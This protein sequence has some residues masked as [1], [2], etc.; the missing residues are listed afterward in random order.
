[1]PERNNSIKLPRIS[2][3]DLLV[4]LED[5]GLKLIDVRSPDA[6]N[7]WKLKDEKRGG[8]IRG[9]RSLPAR[10][11]D[12]IDWIEMVRHKD[13]KPE[14]NLAVYGYRKDETEKVA[15][16]LIRTGYPSVS[17]YLDFT[18]EWSGNP[19]L[20]MERLPRYKHLV[21]PRWLRS[22][23]DT[24]TAPEYQNDRLV[25]AHAHYRNREDYL[26]G[27]IPGAVDLDTNSLESP[28]TWN[29]RSPKEIEETLME[30]GIDTR[31]T[32]VL[33]GRFSFP[34]NRDPF[35]GSSAGQLAAMRCALIMLYAGV[36]DV[37]I[38]N[39]G[40]RAWLEAGY[41]TTT[42][43]TGR[44]PV[45]GFGA[46]I[47]AHP[48]FVVDLPEAKEVLKAPDRN[49]VSVRSWAEY[50]GEV[51]GY[52][53]IEKRG[54]IPGSVFGNCGSDA[55][56]MENYRNLDHTM[57]EYHEIEKMWRE[58]GITPDRYNSFYCGTGWRASEAFISAWLMGWSRISVFDGG[59]FQWSN[60]EGNPCEKGAPP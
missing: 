17:V 27:H 56:H 35:P 50:T 53:Y 16:Q 45:S 24:G 1:M 10:W 38:L 46:E 8:H 32:V 57:R 47:P 48:E 23:M 55:Y 52:D 43:E 41:E 44:H 31:T 26:E 9:A 25:I 42:A 39:G 29:R 36:E 11:A 34:D 2:T 58:G 12:Y 40:L 49:L 13:I 60:H 20:P 19:D 54:R 33:Y 3:G 7:G 6:Y 18:G 5:P 4:R 28:E 21:S 15:R 59:W 14:D 37:R 51:S 22:L 30:L